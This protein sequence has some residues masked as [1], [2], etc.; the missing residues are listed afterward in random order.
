[1]KNIKD[2][3]LQFNTC[4]FRLSLSEKLR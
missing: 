1:M 3:I 2:K 4:S